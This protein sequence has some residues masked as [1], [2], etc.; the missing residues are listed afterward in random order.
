MLNKVYRVYL[1]GADYKATGNYNIETDGITVLAGSQ[2]KSAENAS[3]R[4]YYPN[5][6]R[7]K[8]DLIKQGIIVDYQFTEDYEFNDVFHASAIVSSY[9]KSGGKAW[10]LKDGKTIERLEQT[11]KNIHSFLKF[12][13]NY[14]ISDLKEKRQNIRKNVNE[15]QELFPLERLKNLTLEEYDKRGSKQSLMYMVEHGTNEIFKGFLGNN[16]NKLFFQL[17]DMTYDCSEY[18]KKKY[19][20]KSIKEMFAN[21]RDNLYRLVTEFNKDTYTI[22]PPKQANTIKGKLIMLYHPGDLLHFNSKIGY[23]KLYEYFGLDSDNKDSIMLNIEMQQFLKDIDI[24]IDI[25][26]T[27]IKL[28]DFYENH[29]RNTKKNESKDFLKFDNI[30]I[31]EDYI[32]KII[33]VLKRKKAIILKGVPGVG[34]TFVIRDLIA[35]SFTNIGDEGIEMIQFHQSYSYE[36]FI[37]GLKPQMDGSFTPEKG[38][39]YEIA[40]RAENDPENNYF[41]VIDEINRGNI[42]KIFGELMMLIENDKRDNFSLRLAYSKE[43]FSVPSNLYIIGTMNTADRSLTLV[44][45]ALRRRFSF[46]TLE[47]AFGTNKFNAFLHDKMKLSEPYIQK[48]NKAMKQVNTIIE[49]KLSKDFLIGHSYFISNDETIESFDEWYDDIVE[50]EIMPMIEEYFFDDEASVQVIHNILG[51]SNA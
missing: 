41:L 7:T 21:Y 39:F 42:S 40:D 36:E 30:F 38:I 1:S 31:S 17:K 8:D 43:Y 12:Y 3:L 44:D 4:E 24:K 18:F 19:P 16:S 23:E 25:K 29:L 26:E 27:S 32:T 50:F 13:N 10:T 14:K 49:E 45:Y 5:V 22:I 2:I 6:A 35:K 47:P 20:G 46:F 9:G 33:R 48:I 34:K 37:E 11:Q 51:K 28:W 15:F